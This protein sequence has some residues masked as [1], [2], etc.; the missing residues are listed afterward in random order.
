MNL[1]IALCVAICVSV[2]S[3]IETVSEPIGPLHSFFARHNMNNND[4]NV[5]QSN[6]PVNNNNNYTLTLIA[7]NFTWA[8]NMFFDGTGNLWVS[9]AYQGIIWKLTRPSGAGPATLK[10]NWISGTITRC[11]GLGSPVINSNSSSSMY[12]A[13]TLQNKSQ[14]L[15]AFSTVQ[16]QSYQVLATLDTYL[17]LSPGNGLAVDQTT[18]CVYITTENMFLPKMGVVY[19]Y[20]PR[21][22]VIAKVVTGLTASDGAWIDQQR[23][24]LYISEVLTSTV[25]VYNVSST[26]VATLPLYMSYKAPGITMLD[27]FQI[28]R[29]NILKQYN[30]STPLLFGADFWSN[31]VVAFPSEAPGEGYVIIAQNITNPTSVRQ[32]AGVGWN[33]PKSVFVTEGGGVVT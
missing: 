6:A 16:P 26:S 31:R 24:L 5:D 10:E 25:L 7:D 9:D 13:V 33:N 8:E 21:T 1:H 19:R 22:G 29:G 18:G 15:I 20:D 2:A 11:L 30:S 17:N 23:R 12:A 4:N 27:D 28:I 3:G 14:V 32:G